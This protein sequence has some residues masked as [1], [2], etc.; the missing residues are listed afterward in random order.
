[1][2]TCPDDAISSHKLNRHCCRALRSL[3][4]ITHETIFVLLLFGFLKIKN[5]M[6]F[7]KN[8]FFYLLLLYHRKEMGGCQFQLR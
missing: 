3:Q 4:R 8:N 6:E 2:L 5:E 1:M 7:F